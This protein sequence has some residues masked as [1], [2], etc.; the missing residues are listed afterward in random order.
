MFALYIPSAILIERKG[1]CISV[2][3]GMILTSLGLWIAY[4]G[5]YLG[6]EFFIGCGFPFLLN[7]ITKVSSRWF[8]PKG[9]PFITS[10]FLTTFYVGEATNIYFDSQV[11]KY[12][13]TMALVSTVFI[14]FVTLLFY[15]KP[16]FSPTMSEEE[17]VEIIFYLEEQWN[18]MVKNKSFLLVSISSAFLL[19]HINEINH[20]IDDY[21][22]KFTEHKN[23]DYQLSYLPTLNIICTASGIMTFGIAL[24]SGLPLRFGYRLVALQFILSKLAFP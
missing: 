7:T 13:L 17:K 5:A 21:F 23:K 2:S 9:R 1:P 22:N 10:L 12:L 18:V 24:Y 15:N 14:P 19:L 8:G 4:F 6:A 16:D 3:L 11:I 20:I